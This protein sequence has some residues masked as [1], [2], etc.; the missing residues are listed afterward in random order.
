MAT[1]YAQLARRIS[2][3]TTKCL[4]TVMVLIVG[5][6]FGRQVLKWWSAPGPDA[7]AVTPEL[8]STDG[9][10]DPSRLHVLRFGDQAWSLRRQA[11]S[12]NRQAAVAALKASCREVV[13]QGHAPRDEPGKAERELTEGLAARDPVDQEPGVWRLY[14]LKESFPMV[15]GVRSA[16]APAIGR[17]GVNLAVAESRV[18]T[19]GLAIPAGSDV[20]S[21]CTFQPEPVD[22]VMVDSIAEFEIPPQCKRTVSIR[23]T[24]GGGLIGF[25]GEVDARS[26]A[27][28]YDRWFARHNWEAV[29][30]WQ[31]SASAW[32]ARFTAP[33]PAP[34]ASV[35]VHFGPD[36]GGRVVGLLMITSPANAPTEND[37]S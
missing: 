25:A 20:W 16:G 30:R 24:D 14:E 8:R 35:D 6:A 1:D 21:V 37:D 12:G 29:D 5:L 17:P 11:I 18:V 27:E 28:F 7:D 13:Q 33:G 3:Y 23:V 2:D 9:L 26:L 19:W 22:S 36:A 10:G 15:V 34:A 31:R 32:H 4:L